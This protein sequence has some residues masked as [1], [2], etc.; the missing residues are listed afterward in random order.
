MLI[1]EYF[2][3]ERDGLWEVRLDDHLLSG[4]ATQMEA[5][6]VA[7]ALAHAAALRGERSRILVGDLDGSPIE[8]DR[9]GEA[10]GIEKA[11]PVRAGL[12]SFGSTDERR[13]RTPVRYTQSHARRAV[14]RLGIY[15]EAAAVGGAVGDAGQRKA[16]PERGQV[17]WQ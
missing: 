11:P 15:A 17:H 13:K 14:A 2:V 16:P 12:S 8:F 10:P 9:A 1:Q 4:Q 7:E 5:L 3:R 6:H